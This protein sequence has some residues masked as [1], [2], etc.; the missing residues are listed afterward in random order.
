LGEELKSRCVDEENIETHEARLVMDYRDDAD[1]AL[2]KLQRDR[3]V[4]N[5]R[6]C[7]LLIDFCFGISSYQGT[8]QTGTS[9]SH[10]QAATVA[11]LVLAAEPVHRPMLFFYT[12]S[13]SKFQV[14]Q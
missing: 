12:P 13:V 11:E 5:P 10:E 4:D 6:E 8:S 9:L 1:S 14:A 3:A 7:C 2:C